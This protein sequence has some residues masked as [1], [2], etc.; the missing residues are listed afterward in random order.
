MSVHFIDRARIKAACVAAAAG[1][2]M[3]ACGDSGHAPSAAPANVGAAAAGA[4]HNAADVAFAEA[5]VIHH[6]QGVQAAGMAPTRAVAAQVKA[7]ASRILAD[8]QSQI[9]TLTDWLHGWSAAVPPT[10]AANSLGDSA[11]GD[12]A[13]AG[14]TG[15]P[16]PTVEGLM[17]AEAI[18]ELGDGHGPAWDKL[19][20]QDMSG[21]QSGAVQL[22]QSE[23]A[24]GGNPDA[25]V[26]AQQIITTDRAEVD[27][28]HQLLTH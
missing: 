5:M 26:L 10:D 16:R 13:A 19:F 4:R 14:S 9:A 6:R 27:Q 15:G 28:M 1:L 22:A 11:G 12:G 24:Q 20:L 8:D 3:S 7:L 2:A 21:N 23:L 17:D 18:I 25:R